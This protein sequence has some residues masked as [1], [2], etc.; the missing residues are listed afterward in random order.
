MGCMFIAGPLVCSRHGGRAAC[1][2]PECERRWLCQVPTN[3]AV[4][5]VRAVVL[6][7]LAA[8][9]RT[10]PCKGQ[11]RVLEW[12]SALAPML[13]ETMLY[14]QSFEASL[15]ATAF[16]R[17]LFGTPWVSLAGRCKTV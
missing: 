16:Q 13:L 3:W 8:R 14:N 1:T 12:R 6:C 17:L 4:P 9:S 5:S 10:R 15:C 11:D 2:P 7:G